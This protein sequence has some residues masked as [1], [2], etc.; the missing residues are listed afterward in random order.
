RR[1]TEHSR[2]VDAVSADGNTGG[3]WRDADRVLRVC[4]L[5]QARAH[6]EQL[7]AGVRIH[8]AAVAAVAQPA[9]RSSGAPAVSGGR[10]SRSAGLARHPGVSVAPVW[11][12]PVYPAAK[13]YPL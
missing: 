6:A 7:S 9:L 10:R 11:P 5:R 2:V 3:D 8:A 1:R 13:R 4:L 12:A